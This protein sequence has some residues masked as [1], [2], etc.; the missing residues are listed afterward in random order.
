MFV[1]VGPPL[2]DDL[3][4]GRQARSLLG[5]LLK[6]TLGVAVEFFGNDFVYLG[7]QY[8]LNET[9]RRFVPCVE[10]NCAYYGLKGIGQDKLAGSADVF[11][12]PS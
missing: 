5:L 2:F 1:V 7:E 11:G 10:I 9:R 4:S 8:F 3:V 12:L 6:Q